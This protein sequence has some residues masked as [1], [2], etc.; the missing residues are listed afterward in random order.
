MQK[1][2]VEAKSTDIEIVCTEWQGSKMVYV[3]EIREY[4]KPPYWWIWR[5]NFLEEVYNKVKE[6]YPNLDSPPISKKTMINTKTE[7]VEW[8]MINFELFL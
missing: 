3:I 5:Y 8:W 4:N 6:Y 1:H 7:L 2:D